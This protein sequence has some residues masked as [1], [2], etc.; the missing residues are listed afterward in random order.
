MVQV[1]CYWAA[2]KTCADKNQGRRPRCFGSDIDII[3]VKM[4]VVNMLMNSIPGEIAW[5]NALTMEHW[6]SYCIDLILIGGIW[7]PSL[8]VKGAGE[9][10]FIKRLEQTFE[11]SPEIKE[12]ITEK[13]R[14]LQLSLNF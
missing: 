14:P 12:Q 6:R 3:C 2:A 1:H 9:T 4:A 10:C 8:K 11:K 13:A 7:F 5:M